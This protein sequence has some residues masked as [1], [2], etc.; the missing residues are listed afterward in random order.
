[1]DHIKG[2]CQRDVCRYF[3]PPTHLLTRVKQQQAQPIQQSHHQPQQQQQSPLEQ[4][5]PQQQQMTDQVSV[6][7]NTF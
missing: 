3:H 7:I 4:Q 1:M 6:N 2:K 5:P